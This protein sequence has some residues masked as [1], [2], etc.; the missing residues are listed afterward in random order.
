MAGVVVV[1]DDGITEVL[2]VEEISVVCVV[3]VLVELFLSVVAA[4]GV[5]VVVG[6]V[7]VTV[8]GAPVV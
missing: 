3:A 5:I 1:R 7:T 6:V 2:M 8:E 4:W